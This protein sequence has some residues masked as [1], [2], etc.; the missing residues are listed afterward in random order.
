[1]KRKRKDDCMD[2]QIFSELSN[3]WNSCPSLGFAE[4]IAQYMYDNADW[5]HWGYSQRY[6]IKR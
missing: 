4:G 6:D 3:T 1:M 2:F 5:D